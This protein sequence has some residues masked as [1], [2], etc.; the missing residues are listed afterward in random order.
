MNAP[1]SVTVTAE[2]ERDDPVPDYVVAWS[3]LRRKRDLT[4]SGEPALKSGM[5]KCRAGLMTHLAGE[6]HSLVPERACLILNDRRW[7]G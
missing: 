3:Y 4:H 1:P 6:G 7:R 5:A 2:L